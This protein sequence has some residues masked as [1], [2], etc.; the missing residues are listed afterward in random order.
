MTDPADDDRRDNFRLPI[1]LK[2]EYKRLNSF[3]A[4]YTRNISRGGTFIRTDKP[5]GIGTEFLFHMKVPKLEHALVLRGRVQWVVPPD[6]ATDEQRAGMGIGFIYA[7]EADRERIRT[8]VEKLMLE[9]L[10][11]V[12]YEKIVKHSED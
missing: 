5:L 7:S 12:L 8:A 3:F 4:D 6:Q 11:P 10:G 9:S 1:E 2:V